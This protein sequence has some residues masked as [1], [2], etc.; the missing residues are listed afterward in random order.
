MKSIFRRP[1]VYWHKFCLITRNDTEYEN[2]NNST[3]EEYRKIKK[4][5]FKKSLI[6]DIITY[7]LVLEPGTI[8]RPSQKVIKLFRDAFTTS[9]TVSEGKKI[10]IWTNSDAWLSD[11]NVV[12]RITS[13]SWATAKGFSTELGKLINEK[14]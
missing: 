5:L 4:I 2:F 12:N 14:R 8:R 6:D 1:R 3:W 9:P 13:C 7:S 10:F 11:K